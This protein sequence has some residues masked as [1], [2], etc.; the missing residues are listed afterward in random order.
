MKKVSFLS[1]RCFIAFLLFTIS[2]SNAQQAFYI[3]RNDGRINT[4]ITIEIDSMVYSRIDVDSIMHNDFVVHEVY[5][6]DSI[7]RIPL[8]VIDS[9][10]FVTPETKYQTGVKVI[11]GEMRSHI[12]SCKDLTLLFELGTPNNILPHKGDKLVTTEADNIITKAFIGQVSE[13]RSQANGIEVICEPVDLMDV[14]ECYYG[15]IRKNDESV[16]INTRIITD[17]FYGTNGTRTFSPGKLSYDL[18]NTHDIPISYEADEEL[19]FELDNARASIS[20]TPTIDYNA[21]V[22]VNKSYGVNISVTAIGHYTVEEL[23]ALS[24]GVQMGGDVSLFKKAIPVPEALLDIYFEFG[25]FCTASGTFSINQLLTQKYK[26]IFHWEWSSKGHETLS[27]INVF[28]PESNSHTGTVA[29]NGSFGGGAYGRLGISFIATSSLDIAEIGVRV[30]GG[31]S[32]EG[33]YVPYKKDAEYA[34]KSTDL[35]N[36]IK[37]R[38]ITS[39]WYYGEKGE[40]TLFKWSA[41]V[42]I[43]NFF[44]WPLS[45]KGIIASVRSVPLFSDTK[46]ERGFGSLNVSTNIS[47]VVQP[48]DIGFALFN[49]NN[50]NKIIY[51]YSVYDYQG[52]S[53]YAQET[54]LTSNLSA[55]YPLVKWMGMEILAEPSYSE[56]VEYGDIGDFQYVVNNDNYTFEVTI[57]AYSVDDIGTWGVY[58]Y[59][60]SS[61]DD[62]H[63]FPAKYGNLEDQISICFNILDSDILDYDNYVASIKKTFGFYKIIGED[64]YHKDIDEYEM[65]Y[66]EKPSISYELIEIKNEESFAS[67]SYVRKIEYNVAR[68]MEGSFWYDRSRIEYWQKS[69]AI[70]GDMEG[71]YQ[72]SMPSKIFD[73]L[74]EGIDPNGFVN[75]N[76]SGESR[77]EHWMEVKLY[78]SKR[79]LSDKKIKSNTI[80]SRYLYKPLHGVIIEI[81]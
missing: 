15:I 63:Y 53:G 75:T 14:F 5:T 58:Y 32:C 68:N 81:E 2:Y 64:Y 79:E 24:G 9:I 61:P 73:Y 35:Y 39:Y 48:M 33:T 62:K 76:F 49:L 54:F 56:K 1:I 19:S 25:A 42:D 71:P 16:P 21:Y 3:Y 36:K 29:L 40:A 23:L 41:S 31:I 67:D 69:K 57:S 51:R 66:D 27:C 52:P 30:E 47:G 45:K 34:K 10:G 18:L 59:D 60:Q 78:N 43:P 26:H 4:F 13:L 17:G 55:V 8:E 38:E 50:K 37:D 7:Y 22:I 44:N 70:G 28:K 11:E 74:Y 65:V 46:L 6:S 12:L 20:L 77:S 72:S 80:V